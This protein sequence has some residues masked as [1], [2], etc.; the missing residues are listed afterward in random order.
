MLQLVAKTARVKIT[1]PED[2]PAKITATSGRPGLR[3]HCCLDQDRACIVTSVAYFKIG[4]PVKYRSREATMTK[5]GKLVTYF[6]ISIAALTA[7]YAAYGASTHALILGEQQVQQ[8]L[9]LM[10]TDRNGRVSKAEFMHFMAEEFDRLDVDH[11]GELD[12]EELS[13]SRLRVNPSW[14]K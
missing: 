14:H 12:P 3:A 7:S 11:S 6:A 2:V 10:D 5:T 1:V 13:R 8:L 4:L 9:R